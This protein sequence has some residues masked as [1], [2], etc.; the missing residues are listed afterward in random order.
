[1]Y[2]LL[3]VQEL[4]V[5]DYGTLLIGDKRFV[6]IRDRYFWILGSDPREVNPA[7]TAILELL[8]ESV[9]DYVQVVF[10]SDKDGSFPS[11]ESIPPLVGHDKN[12]FSELIDLLVKA[13]NS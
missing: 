7:V 10:E 3:D 13:L 12:D 1:M 2:S 4:D 9:P 8:G 5:P 11:N 6:Q